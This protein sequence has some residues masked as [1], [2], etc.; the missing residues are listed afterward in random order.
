[1]TGTRCSNCNRSLQ[2][3]YCSN[4]GQKDLESLKFRYLF[5]EFVDHNL[6]IDSKLFITLKYLITKPWFLTV[7]YW[8]GKRARYTSPFKTYLLISFIY[9]LLVSIS[10]EP[11]NIREDFKSS[12][13]KDDSSIELEQSIDRVFSSPDNEKMG[14][15]LIILPLFTI[16]FFLANRKKKSLFLS[17]HLIAAVNL[18]S[19]FF[20]IDTFTH[21]IALIFSW[22]KYV[23]LIDNLSYL[24][25]F[26]YLTK[27]MNVVYNKSI[28]WSI[29]FL[30]CLLLSLAVIT[31]ILFSMYYK[32]PL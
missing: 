30:I 22:S 10:T 9:F 13:K 26:F 16:A 31:L 27:T 18:N 32:W 12:A 29:L 8:K 7:E 20:I 2:G 19:A 4:C 3:V 6:D 14:E 25:Y 24:L 23:Y 5:K 17:H 1:M 11:E 28:F 21:A 15:L